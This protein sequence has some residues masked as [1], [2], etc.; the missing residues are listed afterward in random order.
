MPGYF[1][2]IY[3][4]ISTDYGAYVHNYLT[5]LGHRELLPARGQGSPLSAGQGCRLLAGV[6]AGE[7]SRV[8]TG[9]TVVVPTCNES[10]NVAELVRRLEH[11]SLET[12]IGEVVF[13][14]DSTDH[15]PDVIVE[16]V[17]D[18]PCPCGWSTGS[19]TSAVV[20]CRARS[21]AG[22]RSPPRSGSS[23]WTATCSTRR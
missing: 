8:V 10:G 17:P 15:T 14:D 5:Y 3:L 11:V 9:L 7:G 23:S 12:P 20:A 6:H 18:H 21:S 19:H 16:V 13:V 1:G 2:V 4:S 22:S